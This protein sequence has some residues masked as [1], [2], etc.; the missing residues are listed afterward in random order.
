MKFAK[1]VCALITGS[2]FLPVSAHAD[3]LCVAKTVKAQKTSFPLGSRMTVRRACLNSEV[4]VLDTSVLQ[5]P[6]GDTGARGLRGPKG[7]KGDTG[8]TGPTGPQGIQGLKGD[9][10]ASG[11]QG[12]QGPKGDKGDTGDVG[13]QGPAGDGLTWELLTD[14][15][16]IVSNHGYIADGDSE[17][18]L[19]LPQN[20][21]VGDTIRIVSGAKSGGWVLATNQGQSILNIGVADSSPALVSSSS[22]IL[23]FM[24]DASG[25]RQSINGGDT[26]TQSLPVLNKPPHSIAAS[27]DLTSF[28]A[29]SEDKVYVSTNP[30]VSWTQ[31]SIPPT[32]YGSYRVAASANGSRLVA[33][34]DRIYTSVNGGSTWIQGIAPTNF[35][36]ITWSDVSSSSDGLKLAV[37]TSGYAGYIATSVDGGLNW[38]KQTG[39]PSGN[40]SII[41]S[42]ADGTKLVAAKS[43]T[44]S[45]DYIYTSTNAGVTWTVRNGAGLRVWNSIRVSADGGTII[46]VPDS[47]YIYTS[48]DGG[49]TWSESKG[50]GTRLWRALS[51]SSDGAR[52]LA[53]DTSGY[54][55]SSSDSGATWEVVSSYGYFSGAIGSALELVYAGEGKFIGLSTS[56]NIYAR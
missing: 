27:S 54:I 48:A 10:G 53:A 37:T 21:N 56:G 26:W 16:Q 41:T 35:T 8:A 38:T 28:V 29:A 12:L 52:A 46:A 15:T 44:N 7:D 45:P 51:L 43:Y 3:V 6:K 14:N 18:V 5:G 40:W 34:S 1:L 17:I 36:S 4:A 23:A 13:P 32:S 42:S 22:G 49:V 30:T 50:Q 39:A 11:S 31:T 2:C 33:V 47:G 55:F 19:T 9:T 25:G 24:F 20:A